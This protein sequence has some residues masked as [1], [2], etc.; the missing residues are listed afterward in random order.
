MMTHSLC[1]R[2]R[3]PEEM[4]PGSHKYHAQLHGRLLSHVLAFSWNL[5]QSIE[6]LPHGIWAYPVRKETD[7]C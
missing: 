5:V 2:V 7:I 4:A 6:C 1:V 3:D